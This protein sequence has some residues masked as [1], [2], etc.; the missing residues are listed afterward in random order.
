MTTKKTALELMN[1]SE[2]ELERGRQAA[3]DLVAHIKR[4]GAA[5]T[6]FDFPDGKGEWTVTVEW[7]DKGS[8]PHRPTDTKLTGAEAGRFLRSRYFLLN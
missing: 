6:S 3:R 8:K 2:D 4:M 5:G 7:K 1:P